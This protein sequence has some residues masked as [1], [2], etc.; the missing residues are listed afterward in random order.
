MIEAGVDQAILIPPSWEG[1]RNELAAAAA[2]PGR[3]A[4]MGRLAIEKPDAP[5]NLRSWLQQPGMLGLRMN[6]RAEP[7]RGSLHDG[8]ASWLFPALERH[9]IPLM[10]FAANAMPV[11]GRIAERHPGLRLIIDHMGMLVGDKGE[12]AFAEE[13]ELLALARY[14]NVAV[15]ATAVPCA[16]VDAYPFQSVH[17]HIRKVFDAFG[18]ERMFWGTDLTQLPCSYR[19]GVTLFTEELPW[20]AG[21]D[22]DQVMGLALCKWLGWGP[23]K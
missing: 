19:Q 21:D 7:Q 10:V 14:A 18:P 6:F 2:E 8:T 5:E 4:V 12:S 3:F 9:G 16:A 15:K 13:T 23:D 17:R 1:T 20:L 11:M 22:L